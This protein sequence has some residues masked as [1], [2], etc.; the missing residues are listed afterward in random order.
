MRYSHRRYLL[1]GRERALEL[2]RAA[3]KSLQLGTMAMA[4]KCRGNCLPTSGIALGRAGHRGRRTT[5]D[6]LDI[7]PVGKASL[8]WPYS[9][10]FGATATRSCDLATYHS[11]LSQLLVRLSERATLFVQQSKGLGAILGGPCRPHRCS[12]TQRVAYNQIAFEPPQFFQFISRTPMLK[13]P[14]KAVLFLT[15]NTAAR[16]KRQTLITDSY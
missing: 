11:Q 2:E 3:L 4:C 14:K 10:S 7:S 6:T 1:S 12:S 15:R 13:P 8:T 5:L 16:V 9:S